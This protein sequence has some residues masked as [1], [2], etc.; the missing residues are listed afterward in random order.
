MQ[1]IRFIR[2]NFQFFIIVIPESAKNVYVVALVRLDVWY[3][4][5]CLVDYEAPRLSQD[6]GVV[7]TSSLANVLKVQVC[8]RGDNYDI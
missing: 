7:L 1:L 6:V 5:V 4:E 2:N 3:L 8:I